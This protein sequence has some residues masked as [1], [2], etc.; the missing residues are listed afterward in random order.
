[1]RANVEIY[2]NF[3]NLIES[4]ILIFRKNYKES[5]SICAIQALSSRHFLHLNNR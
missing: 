1:M 5:L 2:L 4:K 3:Q